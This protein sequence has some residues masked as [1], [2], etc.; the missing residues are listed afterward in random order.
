MIV[1]TTAKQLLLDSVSMQQLDL[2]IV[3]H[4]LRKAPSNITLTPLEAEEFVAIVSR[5]HPLAEQSALDPA[6]LQSLSLILL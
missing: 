4:G 3:M 2:A 1:T 6:D 5:E